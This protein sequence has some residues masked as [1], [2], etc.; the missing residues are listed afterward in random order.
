VI[1]GNYIGTNAAGTA[2]VANGT[3]GKE[4]QGHG[5]IN[6]GSN[7]NTI[8]DNLISGNNGA[9][10]RLA[11]YPTHGATG[12]VIK[13]NLVGTDASGTAAIPNTF[14]GVGTGYRN[15]TIGGTTPAE[16]NVISGNLGGGVGVGGSG[17]VIEGNYIGT[18]IDGARALGNSGSGVNLGGALNVTIR[19]NL[20][21]GNTGSGVNTFSGAPISGNAVTG[22]L[23]G[24]NAAGSFALP[25]AGGGIV[26]GF[27]V[28]GT[29]IGGTTP[30][31]RNVISGNSGLAGIWLQ[32][33]SSG[34]TIRGNYVGTDVTG[35]NA[36]P[37]AGRGMLIGSSDNTIGGSAPGAGN[38]IA[39]NGGI[40]VLVFSGTGNAINGNSIF[41]N[42]GL[43]IDLVPGGVTPNDAGD[44]DTGPNE[45][46]NFPVL[47]VATTTPGRLV[48][49]GSIDTP[50]PETVVIELFA[51]AAGDPSGHG[52][53]ETF[54][55]T[56]TPNANGRFVATLPPVPAGTLVTATATDTAGSTSEFSRYIAAHGPGSQ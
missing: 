9:G 35:V 32:S 12:N 7:D 18:T 36:L 1:E 43:G 41:S 39:F 45:L 6:L 28:T 34:N 40:G 19:G 27:G 14:G 8:A 56:V 3:A 13:G 11:Q 33:G 54:L 38:V 37:N 20:I 5:G 26:L 4:N 51:N 23:I 10:I 25:N 49:V 22:N 24:T 21:S 44:A 48:V 46:I 29:T 15:T 53:G 2:A 52:E 17:H 30:G 50:S 31:A 16:R 55:G 42:A 47:T